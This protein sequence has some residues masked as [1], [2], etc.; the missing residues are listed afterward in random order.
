M[1]KVFNGSNVCRKLTL[2][3]IKIS[4]LK[5]T[6]LSIS[7]GAHIVGFVHDT[8]LNNIKCVFL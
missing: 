1:I 7:L 6:N 2:I 8:L 4:I 5:S 3:E